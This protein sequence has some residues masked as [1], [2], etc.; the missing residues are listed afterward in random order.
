MSPAS[1]PGLRVLDGLGS[2]PSA[3]SSGLFRVRP[4]ERP[5]WIELRVDEDEARA[6]QRNA[7]AAGLSVDVWIA[8]QAEWSLVARD[9]AHQDVLERLLRRARVA[10][11][12]P[13][14]AP[15]EELRRWL[16]FLRRGSVPKAENDLPSV[17]VPARIVARLAPAMLVVELRRSAAEALDPAA[18]VVERAAS[19]HGMTMEAWAYREVARLGR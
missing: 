16:S 14:L 15:T 5:V 7:A 18:V 19:L 12:E 9:L 3:T 10:A 17:A 6:W 2:R 13:A 11:E 8:L 4:G 1:G